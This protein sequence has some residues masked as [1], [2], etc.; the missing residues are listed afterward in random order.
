MLFEKRRK[1]L[2]DKTT[3]KTKLILN[4]KNMF[5]LSNYVRRVQ[6]KHFRVGQLHHQAKYDSGIYVK[7]FFILHKPGLKSC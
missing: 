4:E 7:Q 5:Y 6:R 3:N 2:T 1:I